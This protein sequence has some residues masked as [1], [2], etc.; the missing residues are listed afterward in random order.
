MNR[1]LTALTCALLT[2]GLTAAVATRMTDGELKTTLERM[3]HERDRFEDALDGDLK[4]SV[5]R[6]PAGEVDVDRFLT[7]F[8]NN[9]NQLKDRMRDDY[10]GSAEAETVLR[11][12]TAIDGFMRRQP[13]G[14]RGSSEWTRLRIDLESLADAYGAGFPLTENA[15]VRRLSRREVAGM[16]NETARAADAFKKA[17]DESLKQ[18]PSVTKDGREAIVR[19]AEQLKKDAEAVRSRLND[20]RPSA[21]EA[22]RLLADAARMQAYLD[23]RPVPG[24]AAAWNIVTANL[25]SLAGAYRTAWL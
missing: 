19:E 11:Q 20:D 22:D 17:L 23:S 2:G 9:I 24:A 18:D 16:A 12:A 4:S 10:A 7:D 15:V 13:A 25:R 14:T 21:S 1:L 3:D 6:G 8:E 5:I